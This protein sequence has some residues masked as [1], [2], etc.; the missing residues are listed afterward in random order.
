MSNTTTTIKG[1]IKIPEIDQEKLE[2]LLGLISE[3]Q[4]LNS[5]IQLQTLK[6]LLLTA[7]MNLNSEQDEQD[8]N[9]RKL[10]TIKNLATSINTHSGAATGRNVMYFTQDGSIRGKALLVTGERRDRKIEKIVHVTDEGDAFIN[11]LL[12]FIK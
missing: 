1:Q 6:T 11:R 3:V 2:K 4:T 8:F 7:R 12:D 5:E 9:G 10:P